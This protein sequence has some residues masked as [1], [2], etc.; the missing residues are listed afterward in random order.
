MARGTWQGSGTWQTSGGSGGV[1][2][3]GAIALVAVGA[4][5]W[6]AARV[7]WIL[8]ATALFFVLA[9]AAVLW[10]MRLGARREA[11][12]AAEH[13]FLTTRET[14]AP[15][16]TATAIPQV[17]QGTTPPAI[18]NNYYIRIDPADREAAR[19]IRQAIPG[20]AVDAITAEE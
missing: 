13:P 11:R 2:L 3:T 16:L 4:V 20:P 19:I 8:G 7:F 15:A 17:T 5:E 1:M 10:L 18:V 6:I 14:S 12:H 9:V